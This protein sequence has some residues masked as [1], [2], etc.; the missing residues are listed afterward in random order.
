MQRIQLLL[1]S[2]Q[3]RLHPSAACFDGDTRTRKAGE[4]DG[5]VSVRVSKRQL[6]RAEIVRD[7]KHA[8]NSGTVCDRGVATDGTAATRSYLGV[9]EEGRDAGDVQAET[10]RGASRSVNAAG[11]ERVLLLLRRHARRARQRRNPQT[12][13][14]ARAQ[15]PTEHGPRR[16]V[17]NPSADRTTLRAASTGETTETSIIR[18]GGARGA[19]ALRLEDRAVTDGREERRSR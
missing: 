15:P 6:P 9:L 19:R 1:S 10:S 13:A 11:E 8:L 14:H 18:W 17:F 16:C 2:F 12:Q 4:D 5:K 3:Q 7:R